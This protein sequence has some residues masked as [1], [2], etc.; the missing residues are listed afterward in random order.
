MKAG[1]PPAII[2]KEDRLAYYDALDIA[3]VSGDYDD[4]TQLVVE[5]VQRSLSTY[6]DL[7]AP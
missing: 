4:I 6:L 3:C 5:A 7:L 2:H 1:S